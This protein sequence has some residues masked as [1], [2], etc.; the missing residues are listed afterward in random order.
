MSLVVGTGY[1]VPARR[2][3]NGVMR[4]LALA[5]VTAAAL[6]AVAQAEEELVAIGA[7]APSFSAKT[8][9]PQAA[10][11]SW[12]ALDHLVGEEP[13]DEQAKVVLL[14]FFASWCGP[15]QKELPFLV[16]LDA[17]YRDQGLR[18]VSVNLDRD[19]KGISRARAQL[20]KF[21]VRH[22]VLVDRFNIVARRY[23]GNEAPLPSVFLLRRDGTI[24]RIERGYTDD[25]SAG[26]LA[27]IQHELGLRR[28]A[29]ASV[30]RGR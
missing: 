10:G 29:S 28:S 18:V 30:D 16:Q 7:P 1:R 26:L 4:A 11:R 21:E 20:V 19:E 13:E 3:Q 5:L 17:L 12:L 24:V 6:P 27:E 23:L 22:P 9:N 25:V 2:G 15:C 14:S 8:L